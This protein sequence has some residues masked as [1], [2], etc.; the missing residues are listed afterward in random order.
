MTPGREWDQVAAVESNGQLA[1]GPVN[2]LIQGIGVRGGARG[3]ATRARSSQC[4]ATPHLVELGK[5][6]SLV[7]PIGGLLPCQASRHL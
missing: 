3:P 4:P 6:E 1:D 2:A 7:N 5:Q